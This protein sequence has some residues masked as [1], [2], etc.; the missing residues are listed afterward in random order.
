MI[1]VKK[2][3]FKDKSGNIIVVYYVYGEILDVFGS[4]IEDCIDV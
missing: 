3:V 1:N 2:N 4:F